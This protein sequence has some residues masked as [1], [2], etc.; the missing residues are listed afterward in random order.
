MAVKALMTDETGKQIVEAIREKAGLEARVSDL[1]K[2]K[3]DKS[4]IAQTTGSAEDKVM[5]QKKATEELE[6]K[7]DKSNV[8]QSTGDAEDKVMSQAAATKEFAQLS[9]EIDIQ[10]ILHAKQAKV[11]VNFAASANKTSDAAAA[12][13]KSVPYNILPYAEVVRIGGRCVDVDGNLIPCK[14]AR[15]HITS[16]NLCDEKW[17]IPNWNKNILEMV[18]YLPVSANTKYFITFPVTMGYPP[19]VHCYDSFRTIGCIAGN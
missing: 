14:I 13:E 8:V 16:P 5:S 19:N 12:I 9:E 11:A 15:L 7:F 4:S 1:E 6:K 2:N 18:S 3:V 10:D 17:R